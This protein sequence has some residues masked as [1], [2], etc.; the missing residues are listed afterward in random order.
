MI[1]ENGA[2]LGVFTMDSFSDAPKRLMDECS[3][4]E[5]HNGVSVSHLSQILTDC[6]HPKYY[7]SA[8][9]CTGI[10]NR[11][12]RKNKELPEILKKALEGQIKWLSDD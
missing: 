6:A 12:E 7:L 3:I 2:L 8:K 11:A 4:S 9:A 10:I 5:P 1:W